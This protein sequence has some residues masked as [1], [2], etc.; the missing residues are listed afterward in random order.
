MEEKILNILN[1]IIASIDYEIIKKGERVVDNHIVLYTIN[2][3]EKKVY[4]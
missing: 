2:K 3:E 4:I 1:D